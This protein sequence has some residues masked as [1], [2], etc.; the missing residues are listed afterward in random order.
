[1]RAHG[2]YAQGSDTSTIIA[3][4]PRSLTSLLGSVRVPAAGATGQVLNEGGGGGMLGCVWCR[5]PHL[6][7]I[8][9]ALLTEGLLPQV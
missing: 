3:A 5:Q 9:V 7:V 8:A 6:Q 2:S 4:E 1:M